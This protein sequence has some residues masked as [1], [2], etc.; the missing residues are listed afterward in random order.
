MD[1]DE[2]LEKVLLFLFYGIVGS[3]TA[4]YLST[5]TLKANYWGGRAKS[6][7]YLGSYQYPISTAT[8][9]VLR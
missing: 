2:T 8:P 6:L 4:R 7:N 3:G 1:E 5:H 9:T